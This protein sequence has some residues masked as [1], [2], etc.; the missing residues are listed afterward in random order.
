MKLRQFYT[1]SEKNC[2][3]Y[4]F[5]EFTINLPIQKLQK[6]VYS[7]DIVWFYVK[8]KRYLHFL[9]K[10]FGA[11]CTK[12]PKTHRKKMLCYCNLS[13]KTIFIV[14]WISLFPLFSHLF[15]TLWSEII[16]IF[17]FIFFMK[18]HFINSKLGASTVNKPEMG[19]VNRKKIFK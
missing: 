6:Y 3:I 7:G 4:F 13:S 19:K 5:C 2:I 10:F 14:I 11:L 12:S 8:N 16:T 17:L 9:N 1:K 15:V 18:K